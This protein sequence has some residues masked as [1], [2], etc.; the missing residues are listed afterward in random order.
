MK[1][2]VFI[3]LNWS[4]HRVI[5]GIEK[6]LANFEFRYLDSGSTYTLQQFKEL[7][8]WSDVVLTNLETIRVIKECFY[9]FVDATK[10][11]YISH[12][13]IENNVVKDRY[14]ERS[15]YGMASDCLKGLFPANLKPYLTPNGIDPS[16]FR[17]AKRDGN[18]KMLGWGGCPNIPSKRLEWGHEIAKKTDLPLSIGYGMSFEE[19]AEWYH[20]ID[21]LIVTAGPELY[22]ET[23]PLPVFEAIVCGVPVI[24]TY[25]G[26]FAKIPGP[27]FFN[28]EDAVSMI[29]YLKENPQRMRQIAD[30]QYDFVMNNFTYEKLAPLWRTAFFSI[31]TKKKI[32]IFSDTNWSLGRVYTDIMKQLKNE[33]EFKFVEWSTDMNIFRR[34]YDWC[35]ICVTNLVMYNI[36]KNNEITDFKKCIFLSHGFVEHDKTCYL[37]EIKY[38]MTSD[39]LKDLFPENIPVSLMPN[40]VDPDNFIFKKRNGELTN[41]G[42]C[43]ADHVWFKQF[44]WAN[45]ISKI[46]K[47]PLKLATK[48]PYDELKN[49]YCEVDLL[50]ITSIPEPKYETGP[51][52]AFEAI[53]CGIPV[54][55]TPVGNFRHI[56]G[57][58]FTSIEQAVEQINFYKQNPNL[59]KELA[60]KQYQ[61]V[62][63]NFTYEKLA[64]LWRRALS[65][66]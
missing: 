12:G 66:S 6:Q 2:F 38:G 27:K 16:V 17:Y 51:L 19:I 23:G 13:A 20:T 18:L 48:L 61:Y 47:L 43:G 36:F 33:Y 14:D 46:T 58:K 45:I 26:N 1:V 7:Y 8:Y 35:D 32:F 64:P 22:A 3:G 55:G 53:A 34:N 24:G 62:M 4:V 15:T 10:V 25:V 52:P 39:S 5:M 30:Q 28:I 50:I 40:G 41:I 63:E 29:E 65:F 42:W 9:D 56:P 49:W 31:P 11:L 60:D 37:P 57:P 21:L 54:L 44:Q 59:L